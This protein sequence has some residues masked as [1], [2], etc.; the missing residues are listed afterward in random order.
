[1][2]E[3]EHGL[4]IEPLPGGGVR[5]EQSERFSGLLMPLLRAKIERNVCRAFREMNAAL[6]GRVERGCNGSASRTI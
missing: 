1:V 3:G 6:K 4:L 2:L 5:F